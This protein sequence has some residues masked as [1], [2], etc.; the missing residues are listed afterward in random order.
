VIDL[1]AGVGAA[2]LAVA[3][4]VPGIALTLIDVEPAL[5]ALAAD[6]ARR[7]AIAARALALDVTG[8]ARAF[9]AAG[10]PPE[11][12]MRVLMN[13][14]YNDPGR[15]RAS[16]LPQKR[17]AH[18]SAREPLVPWVKAAA[19]L[20]RPRG[21]LTLIWRAQGLGEVL[22]ALEPAFGA[23]MILPV[24]GVRDRPANLVLVRAAKA[25]RAPLTL[26]PPFVLNERPGEPTAAAEAVL[27]GAPLPPLGDA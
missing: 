25:S 18:Q 20:L 19:R 16:P 3:A 27:R 12:A 11:C 14:P 9:A 13:P 15:H 22:R 4:R 21:T 26:L 23:V 7:N 5:T 24:A 1:G 6:N 2:G 10:L 8:S 17:L